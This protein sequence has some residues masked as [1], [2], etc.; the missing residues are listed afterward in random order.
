MDGEPEKGGGSLY[1]LGSQ[2]EIHGTLKRCNGKEF[3]KGMTYKGV[4][5]AQVPIKGW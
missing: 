1:Q 2:Q 3:N 4:D 5:R